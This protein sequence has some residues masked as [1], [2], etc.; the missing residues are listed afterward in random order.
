MMNREY[1]QEKPEYIEYLEKIIEWEEENKGDEGWDWGDEYYDA[2]WESPD[3]G[4]HG[5]QIY[6]LEM[7][8]F[9][10]RVYDTN[11]GT[12]YTLVDREK[13]KEIVDDPYG[14]NADEEIP[15]RTHDF[16]SEEDLPEGLFDDVIGYDNAKWLMKRALTTDDIVNV[17]LV[18]PPGSAKTVFLLCI[19][20]LEKAV[21]VSGKPTSGPGVLNK[22][23]NMEPM[24]MC[25][26]E[27]DDMDK[28]VQEVLSQHMDTGILDET[29]VGKDRRIKINTNTFGS[30]NSKEPIINQVVDR[31]AVLEFEPYSYD[32]FREICVHL[33]PRREGSSEEEAKTI[34]EEV[35]S[36]QGKGDVRKA[37]AIAR[38]SRGDP[39]KVIDVIDDYTIT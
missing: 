29:K 2:V 28:E 1:L 15:D 39:E 32:E 10:E 31:F 20:E 30:A 6:Q 21:F 17:L 25:I 36:M 16:P 5:S 8:G 38:L 23:F 4:I 7:Q 33:L 37:I 18:G 19:K 13:A 27:F 24:Y 11:S 22:M 3:V 12:G 34:A 14:E 26:D 35:W 9:V